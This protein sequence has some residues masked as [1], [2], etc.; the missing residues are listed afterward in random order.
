VRGP[1]EDNSIA[2]QD[3]ATIHPGRAI[4]ATV[5]QSPRRTRNV[6]EARQR[7]L[8]PLQRLRTYI[9]TYVSIEATLI[10]LLFIAACFWVSLAVDYGA[11]VLPTWLNTTVGKDLIDPI[12][13][14]QELPWVLR[15]LL[16][17]G[18]V[19]AVFAIIAAKAINRLIQRFR[20]S[21]L[22]LELERRFPKILGDRL[23]TAVELSNRR[24]VVEQGYSG[25]MVDETIVEAADRVEK[26]PL[27]D[28]FRW[29]RLVVMG[30][31]VL[32]ATVGMYLAVAAGFYIYEAAH[33]RPGMGGL[34]DFH[35]V[36]GMWFERNVM[37][38]NT[39]WPRKAFIEIIEPEDQAGGLR[40]GQGTTPPTIRVRAIQWVVSDRKARDGWRPLTW[41]D[42]QS[43]HSILGKQPPAPLEGWTPRDEKVGLTVDEVALRFDKFPVRRGTP[44]GA[45]TSTVSGGKEETI[46][47]FRTRGPNGPERGPN[48][49][50]IVDWKEEKEEG[51]DEKKIVYFLRPLAWA[52]LTPERL[53]GFPVPKLPVDRMKAPREPGLGHSIDEVQEA[54]AD[55]KMANDPSLSDVRDVLRRLDTLADMRDALDLLGDRH[56]ARELRRSVRRLK[57]PDQVTV[58]VEGP[59]ATNTKT[60]DKLADN[61]FS[62]PFPEL[63]EKAAGEWVFNY[64]ARGEDYFTPKRRLTAVPPPGLAELLRE[65]LRPAYLYYRVGLDAG[66]EDIKGKKQPIERLKVST[67]AGGPVIIDLPAGT[68]ITLY[69]QSNKN[70]RSIQLFADKTDAEL[71]HPVDINGPM[72]TMA[73][74]NVRR[75]IAFNMVMTDTDGVT[76]KRKVVL[77]PAIDTAPTVDIAVLDTNQSG[78]WVRKTKEGPYMV[79]HAARIP[80]S[81]DIKDDNGLSSVRYAYTFREVESAALTDLKALDTS[82]TVWQFAPEGAGL[83]HGT[84]SLAR[85]LQL[86]G[87]G[88]NAG[89]DVRDRRYYP[90]QDTSLAPFVAALNDPK[91][92]KEF[93]TRAEINAL[94]AEQQKQGHRA[95]MREFHLAPD[96]GNE[97]VADFKVET[98]WQGAN[99][100]V[101]DKRY[102]MLLWVEATDT[103]LDSSRAVEGVDGPKTS[104]SKDRYTFLIVPETDLLAEVAKDEEAM[105]AKLVPDVLD[106]LRETQSKLGVLNADLLSVNNADDLERLKNRTE[107]LA[108][109]IDSA[110]GV[111]KD[112]LTKY[113]M[114]AREL[115]GNQVD[116]AKI[117]VVTEIIRALEKIDERL[118]PNVIDKFQKLREELT[119]KGNVQSAASRAQK[120]GNE[121]GIELQTLIDEVEEVK[122]KMEKEIDFK[123][124]LK[125]LRDEVEALNR[126]EQVLKLIKKRAEDAAINEGL[127]EE[128]K[129]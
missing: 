8:D 66:V 128:K 49:W 65:D 52:D 81:G 69:G 48:Q 22:A 107:S 117:T 63:N 110:H 51:K 17:V 9:R 61:E 28:V 45:E 27:K 124:L 84:T 87:D 109:S 121:A 1:D 104:A 6:S 75:D 41:D 102:R 116:P 58:R 62:G 35:E 89:F 68:D 7:I 88:K 127:P 15:F 78:G 29:S 118:F 2:H 11:F 114:L 3:T 67:S 123:K 31:L 39:T 111:T 70:L 105:L 54:M 99:P 71:K 30:V 13:W 73:F 122:K 103:D 40:I 57:I 26:L 94:L 74:K 76:G 97:V 92:P 83:L 46:A 96:E 86:Y 44:D 85:A 119:T 129:P 42:L 113:R 20:D 38:Q 90:D 106:K 18:F 43:R 91:R 79:T 53:N 125:S 56:D 95:L 10:V 23:I 14:V 59:S 80:F 108:E 47:M 82:G 93:L 115:R 72:F 32:L 19:C 112:V 60:L 21:A 50:T 25:E 98:L 37:L 5:E 101:K 4:M 12:D 34:E 64:Q 16:V 33:H 77:K 24:K 100:D 36:A 126:Q 55:S 120:A